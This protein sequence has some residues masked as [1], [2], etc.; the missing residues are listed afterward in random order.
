MDIALL[1]E[2]DHLFDQRTRSFALRNGSFNPVVQNDR[3]HKIAQHG[4]A[5]RGIA[6]QLEAAITVTHGVIS[7][8]STFWP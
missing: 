5:M 2:S 1:A 4:A 7:F 6:A 3:G 8:D